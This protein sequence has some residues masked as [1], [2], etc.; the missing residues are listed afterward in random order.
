MNRRADRRPSREELWAYGRDV[1]GQK[2]DEYCREYSAAT[3]P[4]PATVIRE[5]V[6]DFFHAELR[7]DP[8]PLNVYAQTQLLQG[9]PSTV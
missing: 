4:P 6:T 8:L 2:L 3:P 5:L 7:Y 1:V 9:R